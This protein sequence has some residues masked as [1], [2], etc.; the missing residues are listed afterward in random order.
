MSLIIK[1][2]LATDTKTKDNLDISFNELGKNFDFFLPW[3]G[4]EK[5]RSKSE[6]Q[7]DIKAAEQMAK[8]Y[9]EIEKDNPRTD[10][11]TLHSL[12]VFL[13]RLLFCFFAEDTTIFD[14]GLFSNSIASHTLEDGSDLNHYL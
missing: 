13:S 10:Q 14:K 3:A 12:N 11:K 1:K 8:L 9:D 2:I 6:S 4:L 7:A 5:T